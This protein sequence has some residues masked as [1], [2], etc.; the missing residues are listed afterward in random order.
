MQV[1]IYD[2]FAPASGIVENS[3]RSSNA[4]DNLSVSLQNRLSRS[5]TDVSYMV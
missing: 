4:I 5:K 3:P 1:A 2:A